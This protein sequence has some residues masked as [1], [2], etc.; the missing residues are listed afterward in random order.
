M[1]LGAAG[2]YSVSQTFTYTIGL[3]ME[4]FETGS[5]SAYPWTFTGGNWTIVSDVYHAG[6]HCARS[7]AIANSATTSMIVTM[8]VPETGFIYF[9][10]KVSSEQSYDYLKF[11]INGVMKNQWSGESDWTQHS[12]A[13][14]P[15]NNVFRWDYVKDGA[16][17]AG[18]DCAWLDEIQFPVGTG[19]TGAPVLELNQTS[20]SFGNHQTDEFTPVTFTITNSGTATMLGNIAGNNTLKFSS[21]GEAD[22][23]TVQYFVIPAGGNVSYD[24][25]IFPIQP[26]DYYN[27]INLSTDDPNHLI[28]N[29][30]V[31]AVV[32]PTATE[33]NTVHPV[34]ALKGNF[35]NPFNPT[36]TIY[37]SL[38]TDDQVSIEIYN[39]LG[40]KVKTLLNGKVRSGDHSLVWD[41]KDDSGK[42]VS[43]GIYFYKMASG[44][45][46]SSRKMI[47]M[48]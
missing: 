18:S 29:I 33:D 22:Y 41:G 1:F 21:V 10:K 34:T 43:S 19:N 8:T 39:L 42:P 38:K 2:N 40:Q 16:T 25:M 46:T 45:F 15:G 27:E 31:L 23:Q 4:D 24:V 48:K 9:W 44:R 3:A 35:P 11:Y 26:G 12:Y 17:T 14:A 37:Y 36:T 47:L 28:T 5:F 6:S 20:L 32:L 30:P 7:A 13:C